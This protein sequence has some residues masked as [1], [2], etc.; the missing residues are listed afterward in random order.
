MEGKVV[1]LRNDGERIK[2]IDERSLAERVSALEIFARIVGTMMQS[3]GE[4]KRLAGECIIEMFTVGSK[5][6]GL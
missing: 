3:Q 1:R 5:G 2:G 6:G 4:G